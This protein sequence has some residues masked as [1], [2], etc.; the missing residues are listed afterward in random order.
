M[1][2]TVYYI[3]RPDLRVFGCV[4]HGLLHLPAW[5]E[6][7]WVCQTRFITSTGLSGGCL[8]V[9]DTVYYIYRPGFRVFG[10]V[11]HGLLH[12]PAWLEGVWVCQTRFITSTGL[13]GGCLGVSDTVYYIYRPGWRV[14][15]CVRHG[16]LHLPAWLE[17]VWVCQTWFITSTGLT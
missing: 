12:L 8:G 14:F 4:R 16:L 11:R 7:V 17:G 13:A 5:F 6:G 9:T 10:C 2:D 15:G 1:S 3:Y